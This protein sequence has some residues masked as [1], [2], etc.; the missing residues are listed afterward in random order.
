[1]KIMS[2]QRFSIHQQCMVI[3][4][5]HHRILP[6]YFSKG[7][8][9]VEFKNTKEHIQKETPDNLNKSINEVGKNEHNV[10]IACG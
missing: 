8:C 3:L 2:C 4:S 6:F 10:I 1:M 7:Y 9:I 5:S